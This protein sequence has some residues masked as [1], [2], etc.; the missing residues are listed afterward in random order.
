MLHTDALQELRQTQQ[1]MGLEVQQL[2]DQMTEMNK[3]LDLF[4]FQ[5]FQNQQSVQQ[6]RQSNLFADLN[7]KRKT[8]GI[9]FL[10]DS[11]DSRDQLESSEKEDLMQFTKAFTNPAKELLPK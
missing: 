3:K 8:E 11:I 5:F 1:D 6:N 2:R 9:N 10:K 4:F 7:P